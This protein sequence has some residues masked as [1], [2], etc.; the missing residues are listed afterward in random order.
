MIVFDVGL[1]LCALAIFFNFNT[2]Q[3]TRISYMACLNQENWSEW[4]S[5]NS[6]YQQVSLSL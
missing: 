1:V 3:E 6:Q 5:T 2:L 4:T